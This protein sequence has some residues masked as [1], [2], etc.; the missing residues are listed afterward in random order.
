MSMA[1]TCSGGR[2]SNSSASRADRFWITRTG[3][4]ELGMRLPGRRAAVIEQIRHDGLIGWSWLF[5]PHAW[6][7]GA[8]A[9]TPVQAYE[10]DATAVRAVGE[11]DPPLGSAVGRWAG[12]AS[13]PTASA[14]PGP[15]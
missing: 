9:I 11:D 13:S 10:L 4:V 1:R 14:R 2:S 7:L 15:A 6:R 5:T 8:E 3:T 12:G